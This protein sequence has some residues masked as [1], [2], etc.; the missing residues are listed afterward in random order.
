MCLA[1]GRCHREV[2]LSFPFLN[3]RSARFL[4][5]K[6]SK[7]DTTE[8]LTIHVLFFSFCTNLILMHSR[9]LER[10]ETRKSRRNPGST[11]QN[12]E[13]IDSILDLVLSP[14]LVLQMPCWNAVPHSLLPEHQRKR[15]R[16]LAIFFWMRCSRV[17]DDDFLIRNAMDKRHAS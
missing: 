5:R 3:E 13:Y 8:S 15:T 11:A 16:S 6:S 9:C 12:C 10:R 14:L 4:Y 7:K 2:Y 17:N 1:G